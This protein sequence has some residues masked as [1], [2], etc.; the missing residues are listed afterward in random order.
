MTRLAGL[1]RR[2]AATL[3]AVVAPLVPLAATLTYGGGGD[4]PLLR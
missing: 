2:M 1:R 4:F 3:V